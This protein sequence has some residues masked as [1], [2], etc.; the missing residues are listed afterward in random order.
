[1]P[2]TIASGLSS[3]WNTKYW[4]PLP[5]T[6]RGRRSSDEEEEVVE[7]DEERELCLE[8]VDSEV[9]R[10]GV[11]DEGSGSSFG[12]RVG[13]CGIGRVG[14]LATGAESAA[15]ASSGGSSVSWVVST[16]VIDY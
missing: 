11:G 14:A 2:K 7:V 16:I 12:W 4:T 15:E 6:T 10:S 1:M 9:A 5:T 3:G 13:D 8:P